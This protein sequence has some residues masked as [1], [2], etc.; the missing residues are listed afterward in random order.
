MNFITFKAPSGVISILFELAEKHNLIFKSITK[1]EE[2]NVMDEKYRTLV[3]VFDGLEDEF[4]S[5]KLK[6]GGNG[7]LH[8]INV[9]SAPKSPNSYNLEI[10]NQF[11]VKKFFEELIIKAKEATEAVSSPKILSRLALHGLTQ[12][13]LK[14]EREHEISEV[15]LKQR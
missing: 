5:I 14:Y 11:E 8:Y 1:P 6:V 2:L 13:A 15:I 9:E 7:Q 3:L 10:S 4:E 12:S